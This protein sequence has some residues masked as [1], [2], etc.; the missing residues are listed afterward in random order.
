M[1]TF[2]ISLITNVIL[3]ILVLRLIY[4]KAKQVYLKQKK[5]RETLRDKRRQMESA[6]LVKTIRIEVRKYLEELKN[7]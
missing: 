4:P 6:R 5:L 1:Y 3:G 2:Q 7:E